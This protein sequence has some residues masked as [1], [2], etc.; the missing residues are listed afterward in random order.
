[1]EK[2]DGEALVKT[3]K[4]R[5]E[6]IVGQCD[7]QPAYTCSGIILRGTRDVLPAPLN[8]WDPYPADKVSD[9]SFS[10]LRKDIAMK[11]LAWGYTNGFIIDPPTYLAVNCFY[12]LDGSSTN[13]PE[14]GCGG[15][16][17][18]PKSKPCDQSGIETGTEWLANNPVSD[19]DH[20]QRCGFDLRSD[21]T[22]AA[23]FEQGYWPQRKRRRKQHCPT[24]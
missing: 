1:M 20:K 8:A 24:T 21:D 6:N 19:K 15:Y 23:R 4:A 7:D 3:L 22:R 12:P 11:R 10:F 14:N 17:E 2:V 18:F 13:R 16:E 5:Y 9:T